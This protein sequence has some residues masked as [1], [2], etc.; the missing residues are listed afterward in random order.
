MENIIPGESKVDESY[1]NKLAEIKKLGHLMLDLETMGQSSNSVICSIGAVEFDIETGD[2]GREFYTRIDIQSCLDAGLN[3]NGSTIE[4]WLM[5]NDKARK[6][7]AMGK[8]MVLAQAL[9]Q[10]SYFFVNIGDNS[11]QLWGNGSRLDIGI[12]EDAYNACKFKI[13]WNFRMERDVRTLV[14][15]APKIKEHYPYS[16]TVHNPIDDCKYQI[17]YCSAI[18]QKLNRN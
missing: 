2:I 15:F 14:S 5:Q 3:V 16:G 12:L 4:W 17:N 7:I 11:T 13:P 8:F 18:W 1:P 10:F 6:A 9:N